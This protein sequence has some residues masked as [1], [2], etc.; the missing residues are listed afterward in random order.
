MAAI[1]KGN[2]APARPGQRR[3]PTRG[4]P[5]DGCG[6]SKTMN[7]HDRVAFALIEVGNLDPIVPKGLHPSAPLPKFVI[8]LRTL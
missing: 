8:H 5:V 2:G 6:R 1:V 3:H 4:H 7:E